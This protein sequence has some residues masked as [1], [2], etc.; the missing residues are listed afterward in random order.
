MKIKFNVT[1]LL[2]VL[3]TTGTLLTMP[4]G[5]FISNL[6]DPNWPNANLAELVALRVKRQ[7]HL[8]HNSC[9]T[10]TEECAGI[11]FCKSFCCT[12]QLENSQTLIS[13]FQ[14]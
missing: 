7:H 3:D 5:K 9:F 13:W 10:V 14:R 2:P 8:V 1:N 6:R 12:F 4:R 11:S